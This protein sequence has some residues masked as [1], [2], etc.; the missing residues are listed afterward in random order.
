MK[1]ILVDAI[2]GFIIENSEGAFEIFEEMHKMLEEFPNKKI[3]L[4]GAN[5]EEF[6]KFD[7]D[8]PE[9]EVTLLDGNKKLLDIIYVGPKKQNYAY[10]ITK[11]RKTI[12]QVY[13]GA[14]DQ[15]LKNPED[16]TDKK[17]LFEFN[18]EEVKQVSLKTS[19]VDFEFTKKSDTWELVKGERGK[20]VNQ[21][22]MANL[23]SKAS[24]MRVSEF[25]PN[26]KLYDF[27]QPKGQLVL[28]NEKGNVLLDLKW[29]ESLP[30]SKNTI[31]KTQRSDQ[32][33]AVESSLIYGLPAQTLLDDEGKK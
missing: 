11:N 14:A 32:P 26:P 10:V 3:I 22:Q 5:D 7:L 21:M 16:F 6:K 17:A 23:I 1:T 31:V 13:T 2:D 15:F 8:K 12:F 9:V 4:T 33:V 30:K 29:G 28:K 20:V 24:E 18:R 27:N 19:L 25:F